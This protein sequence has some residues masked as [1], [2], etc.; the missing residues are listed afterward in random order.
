MLFTL[1]DL[2]PW[3]YR[4]LHVKYIALPHWNSISNVKNEGK[5]EVDENKEGGSK[6]SIRRKKEKNTWKKSYRSRSRSNNFFDASLRWM[7]DSKRYL[8]FFLFLKNT[9]DL[10]IF[11]ENIFSLK[12][13]KKGKRKER[14]K[15]KNYF[16]LVL[17]HSNGRCE[18][19][20]TGVFI[21]NKVRW[22]IKYEW[23]LT[24][25]K[26]GFSNIIYGLEQYIVYFLDV[27]TGSREK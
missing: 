10:D 20:L 11:E 6:T 7:S 25:Y 4:D 2:C 12:K 21:T 17:S 14:K 26:F 1:T 27:R 19:Y 24:F 5:K 15:G 22:Y 9:D 3:R 23:Y 8:F 16:S 18:I 13:K